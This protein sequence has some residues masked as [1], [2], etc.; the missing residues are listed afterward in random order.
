MLHCFTLWVQAYTYTLSLGLFL[1][2]VSHIYYSATAGTFAVA[3]M[4]FFVVVVVYVFLNRLN[5]IVIQLIRL[6]V[7]KRLNAKQWCNT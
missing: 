3:C 5:L 7:L 1:Y 2:L 4:S 6:T